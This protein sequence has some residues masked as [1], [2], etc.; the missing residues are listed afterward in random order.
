MLIKIIEIPSTILY[1]GK[2]L[3]WKIR[4]KYGRPTYLLTVEKS[5]APSPNNH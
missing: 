1:L 3:D 2:K 4:K 5:H